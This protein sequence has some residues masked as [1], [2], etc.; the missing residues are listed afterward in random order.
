MSAEAEDSLILAE[1]QPPLASTR[2][3]GQL[4]LTAFS[5]AIASTVDCVN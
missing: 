3:F 2:F 5:K 4:L 1:F